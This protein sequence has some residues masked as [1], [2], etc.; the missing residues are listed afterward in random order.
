M[1]E[2]YTFTSQNQSKNKTDEIVSLLFLIGFENFFNL[3]VLKNLY[4]YII[5][6]G[7]N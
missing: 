4:V 1:I 5:N 2:F 7:H 3:Y 6:F